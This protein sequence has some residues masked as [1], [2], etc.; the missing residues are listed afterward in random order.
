MCG[1]DLPDTFVELDGEADDLVIAQSP[2][3]LL[4]NLTT[5]LIGAVGDCRRSE[6]GRLSL[7]A[8]TGT[9]PSTQ[10]SQSSV[11]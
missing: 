5:V 3:L 7:G 2:F 6:L 11:Q 1:P 9:P 8:G 10:G 4:Q